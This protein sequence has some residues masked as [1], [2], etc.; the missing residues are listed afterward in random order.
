MAQ[1]RVSATR[2]VW[3]PAFF[4]G[5]FA[6]AIGTRLVQV[7]VF[8]HDRYAAEARARIGDDTLYATRGAILDRNGNP[9]A[10]S[11][12]TWDIYV[13]QRAWESPGT[14]A[15]GSAAIAAATGRDA[16]ALQEQVA[17]ADGLDILVFRDLPY[18]AGRE[19]IAQGHSGIILLPNTDRVH[20][21]GDL[22]AGILGITG[23]DNTGLTGLE[24]YYNDILQGIPGRAVYERD[25][26]GGPIP[27]GRRVTDSPLP[28]KD[29]VL[30]IDRYLQDLCERTLAESVVDHQAKGGTIIM[31]MPDTGEVLAMCS[32][33]GLTYSTLNLNDPAQTELFR[34]RA[35]TDLYEPGS[36]MKIITTA[37]A[38]DQGVVN[39]NTTYYDSGTAW[40]DGVPIRNWD[41]Q[42]YGTQSMTGVLQHSI[43]TGAMF[44]VNLLGP[45]VFHQY[46]SAFGFAEVTGIDLDGEAAGVF[47]TPSDPIWSPVDLA[48]QSF[49]Q[50][51]S[52]TPIQMVAAVAAV[53]NGGNLVE[54]HLVKSYIRADGTTEPVDPVI[55]GHPI[56]ESTSA[57]LRQMLADVVM[58]DS[59]F[60]P[61][62]PN[63]YSAGGKSGTANVPVFNG[64]DERA[65]ASFIGF[66]PVENPEILIMVKL[67][68]N[69]DNLTG[70][71]AAGPIFADLVDAALTY[72]NIPP[73]AAGAP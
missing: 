69:A 56:S 61:G 38:I 28:G 27:F 12:D 4:F 1:Q 37:A 16:A 20:P 46:L 21:E 11:V 2:R 73:D 60:H 72:M 17:N 45:L 26:A 39:P 24:V 64:Y 65:I 62:K 18:V 53:I 57:T 5:L 55:S 19:L 32:L 50:S 31:M 48:T 42:T 67:D 30:T 66:A 51:I 43:N 40:V 70:T 54:P 9:L 7:Q 6:I 13:N 23:Q 8:E 41:F 58:P 34:N 10:T 71:Q 63:L 59:R 22:S 35:V 3:V 44:M 49:G 33:P 15:E 68:E 25:S 14:A 52:V 36:V 29:I 47:R